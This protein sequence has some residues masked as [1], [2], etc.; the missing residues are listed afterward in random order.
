MARPQKY[1]TFVKTVFR[2]PDLP[3]REEKIQETL[4]A[5]MQSLIAA[6]VQEPMSLWEFLYNQS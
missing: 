2:E 3:V 6:Q 1:N 4:Q 5:A